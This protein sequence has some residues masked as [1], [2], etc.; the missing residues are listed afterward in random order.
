MFGIPNVIVLDNEKSELERIRDAFFNA[1]IPCLP[2][3]YKNDDPDNES[4]IDHVN[5]TQNVIPRIIVSD[6]NLT[7]AQNA[8]PATLVGPLVKAISHL[9]VAGPYL[10][11][12]WSKHESDVEGVMEL[13]QE[14]YQNQI[15]MP[16]QWM[17]ISKTEFL[18]DEGAALKDKV[19]QLI[20]D[21]PLFE[22][23]LRWESRIS[24]AARHT[25]N[26]LFSL[27]QSMDDT[28]SIDGSADQLKTI[29]SKIGN[30]ALGANNAKESP[31]LAIES[32]LTPVLEDQLRKTFQDNLDGKWKNVL[33]DIGKDQNLDEVVKSKLNT[34]YHIEEVASDTPKDSRGVFVSLNKSYFDDG[35]NIS[36]FRSRIG[37][38]I[39]DVIHQE[40]LSRK[41]KSEGKAL[42]KKAREETIIGFL[43]VSAACDYA[44]KKTKLPKYILGALIPYEY[45][46]LTVF[47]ISNGLER[48]TA[49][50][51][52]IRLPIIEI[53]GRSYIVKFSFKYK[54]GVQPD[55]NKWFG[56]SIFRVRD[57]ILSTIL[58]ESS[59][60]ES[61]PGVV[62]F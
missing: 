48:Q 59:R 49:H 51:G 55:D 38:S 30:E 9:S 40:F 50:E 52:V 34:F 23:I 16:I 41:G 39:E 15:T 26:E 10:L 21:S 36:K 43:E 8:K 6:L 29:L 54:F 37:R 56:E 19:R 62:S 25:T 3:E 35:D 20:S 31:T 5:I 57:Q 11:C 27:A 14:R 7:E 18:E 17:V 61:R 47:K 1:C 53:G 32:G 12:I 45:A 46:E 60:Y 22:M 28:Q 44:Q 13:I 33:P 42:T 58:F 4:G 24:E 2:I